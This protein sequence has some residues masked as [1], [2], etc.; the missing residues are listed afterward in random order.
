MVVD[1]GRNRCTKNGYTLHVCPLRPESRGTIRLAQ[2]RPASEPRID[3]NYLAERDGPRHADRR[4]EDGARASGAQPA[5]DPLRAEEFYP[6]RDVRP[7]P[8]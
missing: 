4:R 7:T 1:H 5:F 2:Q 3:A 8:S 6:A